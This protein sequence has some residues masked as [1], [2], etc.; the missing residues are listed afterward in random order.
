MSWAFSPVA[1]K[2][3]LA[4]PAHPRCSSPL[5]DCS[6][7]RCSRRR[8]RH[9][10]IASALPLP[11]RTHAPGTLESRDR[12]LQRARAKPRPA[13]P[14]SSSPRPDFG[15]TPHRTAL[16]APP[17]PQRLVAVPPSAA[18]ASS[19]VRPRSLPSHVVHRH[20][21]LRLSPRTPAP[22]PPPPLRG[23]PRGAPAPTARSVLLGLGL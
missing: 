12:H 20:L 19:A 5:P 11:D 10:E 8:G 13:A 17:L 2:R 3:T 6:S 15:T 21:Q 18:L 16:P 14:T 22:P 4:V 7:S 1:A 9:R 23:S